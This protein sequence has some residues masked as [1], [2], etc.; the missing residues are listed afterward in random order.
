MSLRATVR[1]G[2]HQT[3]ILATEEGDDCLKAVLPTRPNHPRALSTLMEGLALWHG[4]P[5]HVVLVDDPS[6]PSLVDGLGGG[7]MGPRDLSNVR[8]EIRQPTRRTRIRGPGDF[9]TLYL[10]HGGV[11]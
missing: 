8:F 3:R 7:F 6:R 4:R 11:R 10:F 1:P 5:L 9:R 2:P